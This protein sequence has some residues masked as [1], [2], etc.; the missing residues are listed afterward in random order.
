MKNGFIFIS[1]YNPSSAWKEKIGP[2]TLF[3]TFCAIIGTSHLKELHVSLC[4]SGVT[5]M[6]HFVRSKNLYYLLSEIRRITSECRECLEMK[7][8]FVLSQGS[9]LIKLTQP[10][11]RLNLDFKGL[12]P[13]TTKSR[14][15]LT[16]IDEY[17]RFPFAFPCTHMT[18]LTVIDRST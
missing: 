16:I 14:Y 7:P 15:F 1:F 8:Q 11:E 18:P 3:R 17:T 13:S 2:D 4:H 5:R 9:C 6:A 12:L 10:L